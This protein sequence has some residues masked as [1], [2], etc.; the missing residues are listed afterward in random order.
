LPHTAATGYGES[1]REEIALHKAQGKGVRE[2]ARTIG[3]DP[4][5]VPREVRRNAA[6]RSGKQVYRAVLAQW[7]AQQ[8]A[9]RPKTAKLVTD[10]RS[11]RDLGGPLADHH[12]AR[13]VGAGLAA[14][15]GR[16]ATSSR[17]IQPPLQS[18]HTS[19]MREVSTD[20]GL[21]MAPLASSLST[22]SEV[23]EKPER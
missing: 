16:A 15:S 18:V 1:A 8:A 5:T 10:D 23:R 9:K 19:R 21:R 7:K 20:P 22:I 3:R 12:L 4:G 14:S 13:D 17:F 2:I 11:V 6:T